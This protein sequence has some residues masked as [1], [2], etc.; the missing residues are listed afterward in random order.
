MRI[1]HILPQ[2]A[3]GSLPYDPLNEP[4][5]GLAGAAW[6]LAA[7][8]AAAGHDVEIVAPG[9]NGPRS[10][11]VA[12]VLVNWLRPWRM[13]RT[14]SI[15][16]SHLFPL[17]LHTLRSRRADIAHVHGN[18]YFR[19]R[20]MSSA[21]VL[22]VQDSSIQPGP[23]MMGS[24]A[25]YDRVICCSNYIREQFLRRLPYP[26]EQTHVLPNGVDWQQHANVDRTRARAAL[27]IP[28]GQIVLLFSGRIIPDKGLMVLLSA[29]ERLLS[30]VDPSPLLVVSG[31]GRMGLEGHPAAWEQAD[32]YEQQVRQAAGRL[33]VWLIGA[34]PR[35]QMPS[36]YRAA[37]IFVC[38][39]IYQEPL[40]MVNVEAQACGTPVVASAVGGIPDVVQH[41][42][43]GLL[44]PPGDAQALAD[45]LLRLILDLPLRARLGRTA[46]E[47]SAEL[48][49]RLLAARLDAIYDRALHSV[50]QMRPLTVVR[51]R[52]P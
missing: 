18:P 15:D 40:G 30:H 14:R 27:G 2:P 1:R 8:Q 31:S 49:W 41:E 10:D 43:N 24:L 4:M 39:S 42:V 29:L 25:G 20:G 37:D 13:M 33:S 48:D 51:R 7:A 28:E 22:H 38:P 35:A 32:A 47:T 11:R 21:G 19:L 16:L 3:L 9:A 50:P 34:T 23:K 44:V 12:G 5:T 52:A 46:R 26:P 45:A 6:S 17:A 36:L